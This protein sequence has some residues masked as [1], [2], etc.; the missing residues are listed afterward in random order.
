MKGY[1][2]AP[3]QRKCAIAKYKLELR[4]SRVLFWKLNDGQWKFKVDDDRS[5]RRAAGVADL[6]DGDHN[7]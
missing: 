6:N 3:L 7:H 2:K 4:I 5:R 1:G